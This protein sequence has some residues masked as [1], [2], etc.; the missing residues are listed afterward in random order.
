MR[1]QRLIICFSILLVSFATALTIPAADEILNNASVIELQNLNLGDAVII[2]KIKTSECNFDTSIGGL[3]QLQQAKVSTAVI[4]V[5]LAAK[6]SSSAGAVSAATGDSN[7]PAA[8]HP[9]GVWLLQETKGQKKMIP[10]EFQHARP[11][12]SGSYA[13]AG[14]G[15]QV[16]QF[17]SL[18]GAQADVQLSERRPVFY[19]YFATGNQFANQ[20][21]AYEFMTMQ[22]PEDIMLTKFEIRK[23]GD[24]YMRALSLSKNGAYGGS[25]TIDRAMRDLEWEKIGEGIYKVV[26]KKDLANGEF[27]FSSTVSGGYGQF[28][29]FGIHSTATTGNAPDPE[30]ESLCAT[31]K[32][33]KPNEQIQALKALRTMDAPEAVPSI[34]P[35]L[36]SS[37]PNVIRDACRTLAVLGNKDVIASIEPLL[38]HSRADVRKDAQDAIDLLQAR[39]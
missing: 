25:S 35:C 15:G 20:G 6:G 9:A 5:M 12:T 19:F 10:I 34:L 1:P 29:P 11:Q 33:G 18:A 36:T 2:E 14:W 17:V 13:W 39:P 3:K 8:P 31:L 4:Q 28:F 7:D 26:P 30:V 27:A 22:N 38:K 24:H 23:N 32:S 21:G 37:N 16:E